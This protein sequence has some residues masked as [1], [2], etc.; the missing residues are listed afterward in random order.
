MKES[1]MF[2]YATYPESQVLSYPLNTLINRP[3]KL[4]MTQ[5]K[6]DGCNL[7]QLSLSLSGKTPQDVAPIK[8]NNKNNSDPHV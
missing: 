5:P 4:I 2:F 3:V 7:H 8:T 1:M 6:I